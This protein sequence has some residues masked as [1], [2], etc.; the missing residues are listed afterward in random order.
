MTGMRDARWT[1]IIP[2]KRLSI[3]KS[4]LRGA[5]ADD[6]LVLAI[7]LDTIDAARE[8]DAVDR[9][10]VV[11]AD[12]TIAEAVAPLGAE[13]VADRPDAGL[14]PAIAQGDSRARS[15]RPRAALLADLPAL[16]SAEL[17]D[18]LHKAAG[19]CT[20]A[21][22]ADHAGSGTTLLV[23]PPGIELDPRFGPGSAAAHAAS[24]AAALDGEWPS[25]RLDVDTAVDLAAA[26]QIG[27][28]RH[29]A[30]VI[31]AAAQAG[32]PIAMIDVTG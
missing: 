18:A 32:R 3:G 13:V 31:R 12:A 26:A 25:L 10:F 20:R 24:G 6:A 21:Y 23:A 22:V 17:T 7:A 19:T 5:P 8:S 28:G 4:R 16:R 29:T 1:I 2:V 9:V 15:D 27:L 11:T 14:N 30:R